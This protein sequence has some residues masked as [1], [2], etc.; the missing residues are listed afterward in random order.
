VTCRMR[1]VNTV[2][3]AYTIGNNCVKVFVVS[4]R[5]GFAVWG[6][7][8][9]FRHRR[10]PPII[11]AAPGDSRGKV[12]DSRLAY[13]NGARVKQLNAIAGKLV[14]LLTVC[15]RPDDNLFECPRRQLPLIEF[16]LPYHR[17]GPIPNFDTGYWL[18]NW[19]SLQEPVLLL[20]TIGHCGKM[21]DRVLQRVPESATEKATG[22][23]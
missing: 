1:F 3:R 22:L 9:Q 19:V 14:R 10:S 23:Y 6:Q 21:P 20:V 17:V 16:P 8:E 13:L 18:I 11:C 12:R 15:R 4:A 2:V 7:Q 5:L